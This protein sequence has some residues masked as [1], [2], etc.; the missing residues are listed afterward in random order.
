MKRLIFIFFFLLITVFS[1]SQQMELQINGN[2]T[3]DNS[4]YSISEAGDDYQASI[5]SQSSLYVSIVFASI[6]DK[7]FN[8]NKK[9][10]VSINKTE[11]IY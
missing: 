7:N 8:P 4:S 6:W 2:I 9:W 5:Q 3:F 10:N 11:I 1:F